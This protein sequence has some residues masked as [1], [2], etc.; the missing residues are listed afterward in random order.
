MSRTFYVS[1]G[2]L[3]ILLMAVFFLISAARSQ[4]RYDVGQIT[5]IHSR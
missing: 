3:L 1:I 5:V 4:R 2:I